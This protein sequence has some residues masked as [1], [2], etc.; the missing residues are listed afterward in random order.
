MPTSKTKATR[1]AVTTRLEQLSDT[2]KRLLVEQLIA[3]RKKSRAGKGMDVVVVLE[4]DALLHNR[5]CIHCNRKFLAGQLVYCSRN[6]RENI[7]A[8]CILNL[9]QGL[10]HEITMLDEAVLEAEKHR[11]LET[12]SFFA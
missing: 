6:H 10:T 5:L 3:A 2:A 8:R 11:M 7:H 1:W 12:G 4:N 9:A